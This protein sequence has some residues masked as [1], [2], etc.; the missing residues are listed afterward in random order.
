MFFVVLTLIQRFLQNKST[1]SRPSLPCS[2]QLHT[3]PTQHATQTP[4]THHSL[5]MNATSAAI[6]PSAGRPLSR[7]HSRSSQLRVNGV[8]TRP[9]MTLLLFC[10]CGVC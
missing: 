6:V 5:N 8:L 3:T 10:V 9:S 1:T 4:T 7:K 2:P